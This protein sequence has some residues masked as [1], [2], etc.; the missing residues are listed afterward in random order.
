MIKFNYDALT[1]EV[2]TRDDFSY[3]EREKHGIELLK[4]IH[5]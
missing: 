2:V 5:W 1:G 4:N 3:E